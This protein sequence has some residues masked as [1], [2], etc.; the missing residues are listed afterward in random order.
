MTVKN[1]SM[2]QE[3][4][5]VNKDKE[6]KLLGLNLLNFGFVFKFLGLSNNNKKHIIKFMQ[7][8]ASIK[9]TCF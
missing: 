2:L 8:I 9:W 7:S 5:A 6:K 3:V 4:W 1:I